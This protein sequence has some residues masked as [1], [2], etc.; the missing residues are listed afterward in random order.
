[1]G[2]QTFTDT[3]HTEQAGYIALVWENTSAGFSFD[4]VKVVQ[5]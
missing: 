3:T 1:M 4:D 2:T 5:K